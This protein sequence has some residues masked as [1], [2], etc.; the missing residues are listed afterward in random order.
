[1][2]QLDGRLVYTHVISVT[3]TSTGLGRSLTELAL[4]KG[5]I[6]VATARS[7]AALDDLAQKYPSTRLLVLQLDITQKDA[8]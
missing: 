2:D 8:G 1:M 4:E 5:E 7:P 3:G 6:V